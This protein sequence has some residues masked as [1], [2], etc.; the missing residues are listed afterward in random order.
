MT[1]WLGLKPNA[2]L[3]F[4]RSH[5]TNWHQAL[6]VKDPSHGAALASAKDYT[7]TCNAMVCAGVP[8]QWCVF[9][10]RELGREKE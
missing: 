2:V 5:L 4:L 3:E 10:E 7:F 6:A 9:N 8:M 1:L